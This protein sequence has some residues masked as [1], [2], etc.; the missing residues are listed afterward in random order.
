[1]RRLHWRLMAS[2][3]GVDGGGTRHWTRVGVG[4]SGRAV[5][6]VGRGWCRVVMAIEVDGVDDGGGKGVVEMESR[7]EETALA[8]GLDATAL[9]M[10]VRG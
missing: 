10:W 4:G 7:V 5:A 1:M 8:V 9:A 3:A 6:H 2:V